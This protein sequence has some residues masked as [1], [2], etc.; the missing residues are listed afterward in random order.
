LFVESP[1]RRVD[2]VERAGVTF[3]RTG[4]LSSPACQDQATGMNGLDRLGEERARH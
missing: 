3:D 4:D 2:A 1:V